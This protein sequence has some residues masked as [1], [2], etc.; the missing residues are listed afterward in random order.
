MTN[1]AA[2]TYAVGDYISNYV[3]ISDTV[4]T[5]DLG[6]GLTLFEESQRAYDTSTIDT[7]IVAG[8]DLGVLIVDGSNVWAY[9][10]SD[11]PDTNFGGDFGW[12]V[13]G[14]GLGALVDLADDVGGRVTFP[15][16]MTLVSVPEPSSVALLGLGAL[17]L[18]AR[19][20]R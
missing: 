9:S 20:R 4:L 15:D 12:E 19:R 5:T 14:S 8:T 17:G 16:D 2:T 1:V 13:P 11:T 6:G 3:V 7:D 18:V 10:G